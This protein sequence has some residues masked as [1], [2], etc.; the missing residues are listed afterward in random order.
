MRVIHPAHSCTF[1][2]MDVN[3]WRSTH[4][5][6]SQACFTQEVYFT[7]SYL[8][9]SKVTVNERKADHTT[10]SWAS[11][12][13]MQSKP[14]PTCLSNRER[15]T[16]S[17]WSHAPICIWMA[18]PMTPCLLTTK[19]S[20]DK[21]MSTLHDNTPSQ[22]CIGLHLAVQPYAGLVNTV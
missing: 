18:V 16:K 8:A 10:T 7:H 17:I 21:A 5:Q 6:C 2:Q 13:L 22:T 11:R 12:M 9:A 3:H 19:A 14:R 4:M 15:I 20:N 1:Q